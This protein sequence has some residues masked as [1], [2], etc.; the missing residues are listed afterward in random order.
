LRLF[1]GFSALIHGVQEVVGSNPTAPTISLLHDLK[2]N[3][4]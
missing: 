1:G 2:L 4:G 3:L